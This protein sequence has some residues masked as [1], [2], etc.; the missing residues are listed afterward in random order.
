MPHEVAV[1]IRGNLCSEAEH[2][3]GRSWHVLAGVIITLL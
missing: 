1:S 3:K 2:V